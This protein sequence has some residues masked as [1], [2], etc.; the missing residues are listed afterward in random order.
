MSHSI[1]TLHILFSVGSRNANCYFQPPQAPP[2]PEPMVHHTEHIK[3]ASHNVAAVNNN[4]AVRP[5]NSFQGSH[6]NANISLSVVKSVL[7]NSIKSIL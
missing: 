3:P 4:I 6:Q 2:E 1:K 7:S 5:E